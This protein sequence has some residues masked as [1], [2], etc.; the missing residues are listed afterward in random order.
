M[1]APLLALSLAALVLVAF[2]PA[3][4]GG[5]LLWDDADLLLS[6]AR[7]RGL[8]L[9][10]LRW[11]FGTAHLGPY[12]PL[13]W[14]S[15][16]LDWQLFGLDARAFHRTNLVLHAGSAVLCFLAARELFAQRW[17]ERRGSAT[18]DLGAAAA[19]ALFALHPLRVESVAWITERRDVLSGSVSYT[20]LTLPTILRV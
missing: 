1:R 13:S 2:A 8:G 17:P 16:A 6:N 14:V 7:W 20:H 19:A 12:Q 10:E 18:L 11:M 15:Y 5:F 3:L 4:S 9:D